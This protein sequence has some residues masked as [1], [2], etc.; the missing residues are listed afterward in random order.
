M[1]PIHDSSK[2]VYVL[3][4]LFLYTEKIRHWTGE[5]RCK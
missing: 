5:R 3:E 2:G 1:T 4:G